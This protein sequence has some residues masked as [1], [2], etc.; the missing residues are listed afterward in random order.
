MQWLQFS[1]QKHIDNIYNVRCVASRHGR[2][3][4]K[5]YLKAKN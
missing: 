1:N 3:K 5:E 2:E 4:K